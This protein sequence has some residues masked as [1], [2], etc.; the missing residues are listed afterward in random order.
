[1]KYEQGER[2]GDYVIIEEDAILRG[3]WWVCSFRDPQAKPKL[4]SV[5]WIES[6]RKS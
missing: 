4:E 3:F 5:A 6:Q 1:M 2:V